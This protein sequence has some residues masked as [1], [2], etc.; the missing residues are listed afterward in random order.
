M[1]EYNK[2]KFIKKYGALIDTVKTH[3][4]G[5]IVYIQSILPVSEQEQE[6]GYLKNDE[7]KRY[8]Q[9]L[10]ALAEEKEVYYIDV[11]RASYRR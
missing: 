6:S 8:N 3:N 11:T 10:L 5:A 2:E 1:V 7:I 9:A 4:P